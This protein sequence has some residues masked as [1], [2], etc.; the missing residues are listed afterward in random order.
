[1]NRRVLVNLA[2]FVLVF[3]VMVWWA[4][5]NIVSFDFVERPYRIT[6]EFAAT[7]G[8][9]G[10][11]EVAYLGVHYGTVDGVQAVPGGVEITMKIDRG[12]QIPAGSQARIFR[13]SAV[14]EPYIDFTPPEG[15]T[16]GGPY[17]ESGDVVPRERTSVPLE[18]SELLRSAS[19]LIGQVDPGRTDTLIHELAVALKGR[20]D[21]LRA[22]TTNTDAILST[23]AARTELL[24]RLSANNTRLTSTLADHR[25]SMTESVTNLAELADTLD[26]SK[27]DTAVLLDRG[28]QLLGTVA[29]LVADTK[30]ELDCVLKDLDDVLKVANTDQNLAS[31]K[32][33]LDNAPTGFGYIFAVRDNE[34]GGLWVR[35][36]LLVNTENPPAQ[37]VPSTQLPAVPTVPACVSALAT[38]TGVRFTT[39]PAGTRG[40]LPATGGDARVVI[41]LVLVAAAITARGARRRLSA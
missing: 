38:G 9:T 35:V 11:S 15:Y 17:L 19:A 20:S 36:N 23:F 1:M 29:D 27:G 2:F 7:T 34:P 26:R 14:G 16:E 13:K 21:D 10:G 37:Y 12:K 40:T 31:L 33:M 6:G 18:F 24:D 30:Q 8:V 25:A 39:A 3:A 41:A 22:L 32:Y 4:I 28:T 5:N